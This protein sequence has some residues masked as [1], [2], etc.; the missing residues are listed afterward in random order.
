MKKRVLATLMAVCMV[1]VGMTGCGGSASGTSSIPQEE[2]IVESSVEGSRSIE[3][4][5]ESEESESSQE[6]STKEEGTKEDV[7]ANT[8]ESESNHEEKTKGDLYFAGYRYKVGISMVWCVYKLSLDDLSC[9]QI[10]S[11]EFTFHSPEYRYIESNAY[12]YVHLCGSSFTYS[13]DFSK[14]AASL[15]LESGEMH[16]GWLNSDGT[17]TD[18]SEATGE[19]A[20]SE[21]EAARSFTAMGFSNDGKFI[22]QNND[23]ETVH[24]VY[25]DSPNQSYDDD[26]S[27]M[28]EIKQ[29]DWPAIYCR[30]SDWWKEDGYFLGN[31][32]QKH[33]YF[34][35][36]LDVDDQEDY[37]FFFPTDA[38]R[39]YCDMKLSPDEQSVA[40]LSGYV[41]DGG[42]LAIYTMDLEAKEPIRVEC[43]DLNRLLWSELAETRLLDWR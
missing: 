6:E 5:I 42:D 10:S 25:V 18:V 34:G 8:E 14:C 30:F 26:D 4:A 36:I 28:P 27:V 16:A 1:V 11:F 40:F 21:F 3:S 31:I 23:D 24:Y 9:E 15:K 29:I 43:N 35:A 17:F 33:H 37:E 20:A 32:E 7:N 12:P 41:K 38:Q 19:A 2:S 22:Y 13:E 39:Y